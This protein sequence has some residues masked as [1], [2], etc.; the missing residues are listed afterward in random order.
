MPAINTAGTGRRIVAFCIDRMIAAI[1]M[2]PLWIQLFSS[3]FTSGRFEVEPRWILLSGVMIFFYRWLFLFFLGGTVGKLLMGLQV[4]SVHNSRPA[5]SEKPSL[6]LFQS[7]LRV[8]TDGLSI[9]FGQS[10]RALAFLRYDRTHVSDWVAETRVV[11]FVPRKSPVKRR[12]WLALFV[13]LFSFW[14]T[15]QEIYLTVHYV[16]Y[17]SG[18]L[19]FDAEH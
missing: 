13:I 3:Y 2:I 15:F 1:F 10:L 14:N 19:I 7:F 16:H 18:K 11:Q 6:G 5:F 12:V 17:D 4:I 8:L 9:F